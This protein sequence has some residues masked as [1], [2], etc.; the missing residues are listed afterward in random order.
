MTT[1]TMFFSFFKQ[2]KPIRAKSNQ[3]T[4][5]NPIEYFPEGLIIQT[6]EKSRYTINSGG[7]LNFQTWQLVNQSENKLERDTIPE[8]SKF[9]FTESDLEHLANGEIA[10][11]GTLPLEIGEEVD[12]SIASTIGETN[13][14]R[15][16]HYYNKITQKLKQYGQNPEKNPLLP[17]L[18]LYTESAAIEN[19]RLGLYFSEG[20]WKLINSKP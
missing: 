15:I 6:S 5:F 9:G 10:A 7:F 11:I 18:I 4:P 1:K 14:G 19:K 2:Q 16:K 3:Y 17:L 13:R 8:E 20:K 12:E